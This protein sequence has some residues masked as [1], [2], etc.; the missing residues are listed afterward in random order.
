MKPVS[1]T[2][3]WIIADLVQKWQGNKQYMLNVL[4]AMPEEHYGFIPATGMMSF[5]EQASHVANGFNF[6]LQKL[7]YTALPGIRAD[8]KASILASYEQIFDDII[9]FIQQYDSGQLSDEQNTW[10]GTT[11]NNRLL[12][13]LDNHLAHHRGQLIIYLRLKG[14]KAPAYIGW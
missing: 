7:N 5:Q 10:F 9:A 1:A 13:L 8:N 14:I 6:H 4:E 11:T 3:Q 2:N 12:Y